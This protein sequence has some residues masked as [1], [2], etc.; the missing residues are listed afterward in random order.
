MGACMAEDAAVDA[1]SSHEP[2]WHVAQW[3]VVVAALLVLASTSSLPA[4]VHGDPDRGATLARGIGISCLVQAILTPGLTFIHRPLDYGFWL[5]VPGLLILV[6]GGWRAFR[7]LAAPSA[8]SV[9]LAAG[10]A[11]PF[12]A[13]S[14]LADDA[15]EVVGSLLWA[16]YVGV[17]VLAG[18][19]RARAPSSTPLSR[20]RTVAAWG[21]GG[22]LAW[23]LVMA[24][25]TQLLETCLYRGH[26]VSNRI[27]AIA[28]LM[29]CGGAQNSFHR[30][31]HYGIGKQVFANPIDG[32]GFPDLCSPP[33]GDK[34]GLID[35][36]FARATDPSSHKSGY[37]FADITH[38]SDGTLLDFSKEFALCA[39][40]AEYGKT[41]TMTLVLHPSG[42][43][44][45]KDTGGKPVTRW[46]NLREDG[47]EPANEGWLKH[48]DGWEEFSVPGM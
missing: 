8:R 35:D 31:D 22:F 4:V 13:L 17:A 6:V 46:P 26:V 29:A 32:R 30:A 23:V 11:G 20:F 2:R 24:V 27:G 18:W 33:S 5:L 48:E 42:Q 16:A 10:C 28:S 40:P 15:G 38:H 45:Q 44:Y 37:Y 3:C 47:W 1:V 41:G 43:V 21:S 9:L 34:L 14:L 12:A 7:G 39:V 36:A 19:Q 25:A